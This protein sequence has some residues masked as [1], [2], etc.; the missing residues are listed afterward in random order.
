MHF[1]INKILLDKTLEIVSKY[2]DPINIVYEMRC[3]LINVSNQF[4]EFKATNGIMSIYKKIDVDNQKVIVYE[5]GSF[6]INS[7]IF[8]SSVK[9]LTDQITIRNGNDNDIE[10]I[11]GNTNY[12]LTLVPKENFLTL[13]FELGSNV[14]EINTNDFRKGYKNTSFAVSQDESAIYRCVN[15]KT[16]N[17]KI[18]FSATDTLRMAYQLIKSKT[19]KEDIEFSLENQYMKELIPSD[20]PEKVIM[21]VDNLKIGISYKNTIIIS[22]FMDLPFPDLSRIIPNDFNTKVIIKR[23]ELMDMLNKV[24]IVS[25]EKQNRLEVRIN[26]KDFSIRIGVQE[27]GASFV[28]TSNFTLEGNPVEFDINSNFLKDAISVFKDDISLNIDKNI[29]RILV[30][31]TS[32]PDLKQLIAP[33]RK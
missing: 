12:N 25:T 14:F 28:K 5:E 11:Q 29:S 17:D 1:K 30:L 21:S 4:I 31:S 10:I 8:K 26:K 22:K 6:L 15:F 13:D 27:I 23:D 20:A 19:P 33:K 18:A 2:V 16:I 32:E 7:S 9:K 24:A 3:I